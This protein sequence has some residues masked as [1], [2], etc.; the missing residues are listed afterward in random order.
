VGA[1]VQAVKDALAPWHAG[2]GPYNF[3][4]TAAGA[5]AVLPP[6]SFSRLQEIKATYDPD[7]FII[8]SHPV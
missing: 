8:S 3:D 1:H 5:A 2:Y 6:T 4:E 7:Q